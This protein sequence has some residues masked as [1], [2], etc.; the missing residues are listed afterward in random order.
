MHLP[1]AMALL[2]SNSTALK[3]DSGPAV[4]DDSLFRTDGG[5]RFEVTVKGITGAHIDVCDEVT[6]GRHCSIHTA[7]TKGAFVLLDILVRDGEMGKKLIEIKL[8]EFPANAPAEVVAFS[9]ALAPGESTITG[10]GWNNL[11][12]ISLTQKQRRPAE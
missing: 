9:P 1:L 7:T 10:K 4:P 2:L 11:F 8:V 5:E 3:A 6:V 12:E